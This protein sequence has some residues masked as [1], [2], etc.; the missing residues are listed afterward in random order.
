MSEEDLKKF[1]EDV[2]AD[3][4]EAGELEAGKAEVEGEEDMEGEDME[5]EMGDEVEAMEEDVNIDE[6]LAEILAEEEDEAMEE[7]YGEKEL[8]EGL[9]D[10]IVKAVNRFGSSGAVED[11][12]KD[13]PAKVKAGKKLEASGKLKSFTEPTDDEVNAI[14]KAARIVTGKQFYP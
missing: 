6:L 7:G 10:K 13:I 3:M 2:I 4:V 8:D 1:I 11:L 9:M 12:K 14:V 5:M